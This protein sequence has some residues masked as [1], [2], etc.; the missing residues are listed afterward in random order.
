M[1]TFRFYTGGMSYTDV[2]ATSKKKAVEYFKREYAHCLT[3]SGR[4]LHSPICIN[5][6]G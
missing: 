4:L 5:R 1:K 6:N 2:T 3:N